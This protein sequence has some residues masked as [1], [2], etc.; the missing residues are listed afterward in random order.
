MT[1]SQTTYTITLVDSLDHTEAAHLENNLSRFDIESYDLL[2]INR[3]SIG[4]S[5]E[6]Q[7]EGYEAVYTTMA[8]FLDQ[9]GAVEDVFSIEIKTARTI[10]TNQVSRDVEQLLRT[11]YERH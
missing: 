9:I 3:I 1:Q 5:E 11:K 6:K 2:D 8:S 10:Y 7:K 4:F